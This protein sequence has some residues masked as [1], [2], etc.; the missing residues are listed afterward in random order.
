MRN[1]GNA[2]VAQM[3]LAFLLAHNELVDRVTGNDKTAAFKQAR[4]TL[5]WLYQWILWNDFLR[6][7][8]D[9]AVH[10]RAL[11]F[12]SGSTKKCGCDLKSHPLSD[13]HKES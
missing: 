10:A 2:I 6:R 12:V 7:I 9:E 11:Q 8:T 4:R 13:S 1:D 5:C 3:H